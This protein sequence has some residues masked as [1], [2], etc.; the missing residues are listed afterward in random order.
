MEPNYLWVLVSLVFGIAC[1]WVAEKR[2]GNP[3]VWF[4]LGMLLGPVAFGVA[5]TSGKRCSFCKSWIAKD[6]EM[7]PHCTMDLKQ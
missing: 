2:G 3:L 4:I 6:A 7:C 5:L 1:V